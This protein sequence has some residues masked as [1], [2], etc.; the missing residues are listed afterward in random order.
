MVDMDPKIIDHVLSTT[1]S[2]RLRLDF[3][4][5]VDPQLILDCIDIAE[6]APTGGNI[7]SRRW[8]VITDS[9]Q[10]E[11]IADLYLK[12]A[13]N[14][15]IHARERLAGTGHPNEK[16]F[17]SAAFLAE[18]LAKSPAIVVP[19]IIGIHDNSG[20]PGLFDSVIQSAWSFC[21]A[22]RARGLGTAWTTAI[23]A[24][25]DELKSLLGLP[26]ATTEIAMFPVAWTKGTDFKAVSRTPS[27][28][29]TY[30]NTYGL[31]FENGPDIPF[32]FLNGPGMVVEV[33]VAAKLQDAWSLVSD[34]NFGGEFSSEFVEADWDDGFTGPEKGATFTGRNK[35][36]HLGD[37]T[38]KCVID[39]YDEGRLFG[40]CTGDISFPGA[41]WRYEL[42]DLGGSIRIRHRVI[43]GPGESGLTRIITEKP[44]MESK[45]IK[46]RLLSL[47]QSMQ[48]V[49]DGMKAQLEG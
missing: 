40:W 19:S 36:E 33:D 8:T 25:S 48:M 45:I 13:G 27:R 3:E 20:R 10:K 2:V 14:W 42:I 28:E 12:T 18:N 5:P 31:T 46:K 35:N 16:M 7:G 34:I 49:L 9:Q 43:L 47:G 11:R 37:W 23:L 15:M 41:R 39:V 29:I 30:F 6:Q 21:L 22:L 44:E 26:S 24:E 38:A 4:R 32:S 17:N 1:R